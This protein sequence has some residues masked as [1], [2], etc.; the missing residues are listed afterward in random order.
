MWSVILR[1]SPW[2]QPAARV[3]LQG[4]LKKA[5]EEASEIGEAGGK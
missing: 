1:M 2:T 4:E 5:A 3:F